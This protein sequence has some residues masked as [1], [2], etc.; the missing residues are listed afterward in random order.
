MQPVCHLPGSLRPAGRQVGRCKI[1]SPD[2]LRGEV[3]GHGLE[4]VRL[5]YSLLPQRQ[6]WH[7]RIPDPVSFLVD[8]VFSVPGAP[9]PPSFTVTRAHAA[10]ERHWLHRAPHVCSQICL[11]T[12]VERRGEC[13]QSWAAAAQAWARWWRAR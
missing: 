11:Q 4:L 3:Q 12:K 5:F 2:L 7:E 13:V 1:E 9:P 6:R 10:R 8:E